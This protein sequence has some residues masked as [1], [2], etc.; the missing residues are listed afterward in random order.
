MAFGPTDP[1]VL[2]FHDN[3]TTPDLVNLCNSQV[4]MIC[5]GSYFRKLTT[6]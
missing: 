5:L 4:F 3:F 2:S 6:L 1:A